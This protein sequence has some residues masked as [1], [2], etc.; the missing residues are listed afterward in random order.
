M[1]AL[2]AFSRTAEAQAA[3]YL[4]GGGMLELPARTATTS[5]KTEKVTIKGF[6]LGVGFPLGKAG[7]EFTGFWHSEETDIEREG[8]AAVSEVRVRNRDFPF[9][10][11]IRYKPY[12]PDRWCAEVGGGFGVNFSRRL[13]ERI[14]A[15]GTVLQP[16]SPCVPV[17]GAVTE[18]TKQ[19]P[20]VFI[21][22]AVTVRVMDRLELGPTF[23]IWYV[24]RYRD[25]LG[26]QINLRRTPN[27]DRLELGFTAIWHFTRQ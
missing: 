11:A 12:C 7:L 2:L 27:N 26:S 4:V 24:R 17:Q 6:N 10:A 13:T 3:S 23:R 8:D 21:G 20:T 22:T 5:T 15:C 25:E 9:M 19:E 14:G 18:L 16:V 1:A